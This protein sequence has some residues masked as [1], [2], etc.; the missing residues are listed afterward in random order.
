MSRHIEFGWQGE[1][2][3]LRKRCLALP[4]EYANPIRRDMP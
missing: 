1:R 4:A 2:I 3:C